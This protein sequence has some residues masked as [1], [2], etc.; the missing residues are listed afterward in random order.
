MKFYSAIINL[1]IMI[2]VIIIIVTAGDS[3]IF[4]RNKRSIIND[5]T[6]ISSKNSKS[7]ICINKIYYLSTLSN[8]SKKNHY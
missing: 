4:I 3:I 6:F 7:Y 1:M 8:Y 2:I 5:S